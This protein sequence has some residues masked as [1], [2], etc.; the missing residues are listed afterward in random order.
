MIKVPVPWIVQSG[1]I[2]FWLSNFQWHHYRFGCLLGSNASLQLLFPQES[3][4]SATQFGRPGES[5]LDPL[6]EYLLISYDFSGH[7]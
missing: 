6:S 1:Y 2:T 5:L 3:V 4:H 7:I